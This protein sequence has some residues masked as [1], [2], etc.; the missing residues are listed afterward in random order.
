MA[1]SIS[2]RENQRRTFGDSAYIDKSI[3]PEEGDVVK[4]IP[5]VGA[6]HKKIT[7]ADLLTRALGNT[8][9]C[10]IRQIY[11]IIA[12]EYRD[13]DRISLFGYSRGA[14]IV[15]KVA[16]LIGALGLITDEAELTNT[17]K[18]WSINFLV[19]RDP[20]LARTILA[21]YQLG[22]WDTVGAV[23][24]LVIRETL[25]LLSLPDTDLPD[26]VQS[27]L[28]VV[29]YHENRKLFNV[30]LF[31]GKHSDQD[32]ICKQTLFP[33]CHSDVG[34][35]G[36]QPHSG[37]NILP[38][39]TLDWMLRN[40]PS[41]IWVALGEKL[42]SEVPKWYPINSAFHD[43]PFWKRIPD[44]LFRRRYLTMMSGL[45]RHRTLLALPSPESPYLLSH[46]WELV[47]YPDEEVEN[48]IPV[49]KPSMMGRFMAKVASS[50][51]HAPQK[52]TLV[53]PPPIP[54]RIPSATRPQ[55]LTQSRPSTLFVTDLQQ[56]YS[57]DS[58]TTEDTCFSRGTHDTV[59]TPGA[60]L[61]SPDTSPGLQTEYSDEWP[62][63]DI[64]SHPGFSSPDLKSGSRAPRLPA[65]PRIAPPIPPPLPP[66]RTEPV[67]GPFPDPVPFPSVQP[68]LPPRRLGVPTIH[69]EPTADRIDSKPGT[70]HLVP[71]TRSLSP[72]VPYRPRKKSFL[73]RAKDYLHD[74][75]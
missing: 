16:S 4:Y 73:E 5:G 6:D 33:G 62:L 26:I 13:G 20:Y 42:E 50:V 67:K 52:P 68:P 51:A 43:G 70:R 8:A 54:P 12:R 2:E 64:S 37:R 9:V 53:L 18:V 58:T 61:F 41:A 48:V 24:P 27:A 57:P 56:A 34:G 40:M 75:L 45:L 21:L 28:H 1:N 60:S 17:G 22:V 36:I 47:D 31:D 46:D 69:V 71:P 11:M 10:S 30:V 65:R 49:A 59:S 72:S 44:K 3:K 7:F 29:A 35:G 15:R 63:A 14:F 23:R 74:K 25:N 66:R 55:V 39:V 38:D 19:G 32:H